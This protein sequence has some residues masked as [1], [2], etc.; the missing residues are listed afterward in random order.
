MTSDHSPPWQWRDKSLGDGAACGE[1]LSKH[2]VGPADPCMHTAHDR[3]VLRAP[4]KKNAMAR[5]RQQGTLLTRKARAKSRRS[6]V[7]LIPSDA[8][9]GGEA[10]EGE[11]AEV[12]EEEEEVLDPDVEDDVSMSQD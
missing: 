2:L 4:L 10:P 12:E 1:S 8:A 3:T 9:A 6:V 7:S 5:A 11:A